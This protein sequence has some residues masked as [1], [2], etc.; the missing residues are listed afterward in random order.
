M[1]ASA[2]RKAR[3]AAEREAGQRL[4]LVFCSRHALARSRELLPGQVIEN[5]VGQAI[6]EGRVHEP[7][8]DG[9]RARVVL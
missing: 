7:R 2:A 9:G 4:P 5:L 6:A 1:S 3:R 8:Q